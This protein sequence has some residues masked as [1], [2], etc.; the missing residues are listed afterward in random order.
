MH[1]PVRPNVV[2]SGETGMVA[3]L[4]WLA[5]LPLLTASQLGGLLGRDDYTARALLAAAHGR[6]L[7]APVVV[8]SPEFP[9]ALRL[10]YLTETGVAA[11]AH[12]SSPAA[13]CARWPVSR[14]ELLARLRTVDVPPD[15]SKLRGLF[16]R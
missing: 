2:V 4:G 14:A 7:V 8:D 13:W 12:A 6:G 16:G 3:A 5:R 11:L 1:A 9:A 15:A 10:Y